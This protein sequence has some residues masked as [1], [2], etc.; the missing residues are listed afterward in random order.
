MDDTDRLLARLARI[1]RLRTGAAPVLVL[2]ELRRLVPEAE[3]WARSEGDARARAAVEKLR[4][5][6]EGMR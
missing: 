1:E 2:D 4:E 5:E 6:A 3:A